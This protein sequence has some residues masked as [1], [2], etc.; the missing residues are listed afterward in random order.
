MPP[1]INK[2]FKNFIYRQF[3]TKQTGTG[4]I[5]NC[6]K[7]SPTLFIFNTL[8]YF[9]NIISGKYTIIETLGND[10]TSFYTCPL[11]ILF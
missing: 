7:T 11:F 6:I 10:D 2:L 1:I 3:L 4:S 8:L 5:E 9:Q